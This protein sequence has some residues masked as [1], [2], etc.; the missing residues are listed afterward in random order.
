MGEGLA[1]CLAFL[2]ASLLSPHSPPLSQRPIG[3][4]AGGQS[5]VRHRVVG[6]DPRS[7]SCQRLPA[8][9]PSPTGPLTRQPDLCCTDWPGTCHLPA[10]APG[11]PSPALPV[12]DL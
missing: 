2:L 7:Y 10:G 5:K 1:V 8:G 6:A 12:T 4:Q 9:H 3:G 11:T